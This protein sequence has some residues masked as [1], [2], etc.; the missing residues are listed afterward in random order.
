MA[1]GPSLGGWQD[2]Y[3]PFLFVNEDLKAKKRPGDPS[4]SSDEIGAE[5]G[6]FFRNKLIPS[7]TELEWRGRKLKPSLPGGT[8]E[9][10]WP[11]SPLQE[12]PFL[13]DSE[14]C[15]ESWMSPKPL[16]VWGCS[17]GWGDQA[18]FFPAS[19][20]PP[21]HC[22]PNP[23]CRSRLW[24]LLKETSLWDRR[25]H[26]VLKSNKR[27]FLEKKRLTSLRHQKC[28]LPRTGIPWWGRGE[29]VYLY[30]LI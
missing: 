26:K 29:H 17:E 2:S 3:Y 8:G 6:H 24:R 5:L 19:P 12:Q 7:V 27:N 4:K 13:T 14:R 10:G 20:P 16:G 21:W 30:Y 23:A 15:P 28:S 1:H 11:A 18:G 9:D 25:S 22:S